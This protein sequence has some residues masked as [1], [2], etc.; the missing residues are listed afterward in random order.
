LTKFSTRI[1]TLACA[2]T[3][4]CAAALLLLTS[5]S[6][7][8]TTQPTNLS[9][10]PNCASLSDTALV[11]YDA[12]SA[13]YLAASTTNPATNGA[14][15]VVWNTRYYLESLITAYQA[16]KNPKYISAFLDSGASVMAL[17]TTQTFANAP[18]PINPADV[19]GLPTVSVTGLPTLLSSFAIAAPIPT[20]TGGVSFYVQ[21][22]QPTNP[23]AGVF[24]KIDPLPGGGVLISWLNSSELVLTSYSITSLNA[25]KGLDKI[26]L[27]EGTTLGR[28]EVTGQGMPAVGLYTVNTAQPVIWVEQTGGIMLPFV[29]FLLLAKA[30]SSIA[31]AG[32]VSTWT[33]NL[34]AMADSDETMIV[35]DGAGGLLLHNPQW[36][37]NPLADTDTPMDYMAAE[38]TFRILYYKLTNDSHQLDLARGL[39]LHQEKNNWTIGQQGFFLL[40]SW[41]DF[42]PWTTKADAPKGSIWDE[43]QVDPTAPAPITDGGFNAELF[44]V[45]NQYDLT[46]DLGIKDEFY[47]ANRNTLLQYLFIPNST[48]AIVRGAYPMA[49]AATT[50]HVNLS[51]DPFDSQ[52][53]LT[54][55][56]ANDQYINT[57]W[58]WMRS[59]GLQP[60]DS[61]PGYFL[62]AWA[63]AEAAELN[64]CHNK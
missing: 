27:I 19:A 33:A 21:N 36:I 1:S 32:T 6:S 20:A 15:N 54:P 34:K 17:M 16:T 23:T 3:L 62:R 39:L 4:S 50:D 10:A 63:R 2:A 55:E 46:S 5:C 49:S 29:R 53:Y 58:T 59:Y 57:N 8:S 44:S 38:A 30:D 56:I 48:S 52:G 24:L 22:L 11:N 35:S 28:F 13:K 7:S 41:P 9:D 42:H 14:G 37:P 47:S 51:A 60:T 64:A 31:D 45:A 25:L 26:P 18:A 12:M 61:D 40:K 43:F